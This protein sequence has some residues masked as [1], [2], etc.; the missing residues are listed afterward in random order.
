MENTTIIIQLILSFVLVVSTVIYVRYTIKLVKETQISREINLKPYMILYFESSETDPKS[1]YLQIKNI[2]KGP[3]LNVKF[4]ILEDFKIYSKYDRTLESEKYLTRTYS[5]FPSDY[6]FSMWDFS[7]DENYLEKMNSQIG[8]K[9]NYEDIFK[10]KYSETFF[11]KLGEGFDYTVTTPP[12]NYVGLISYEI[13]NLRNDI[14]QLNSTIK[15]TQ[16][17]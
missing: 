17:K 4:E 9:C 3:A 7:F 16:I 1:Q 10:E 14:Q 5:Y 2:G 13:K 15:K 12:N 8:I 6:N 11:L